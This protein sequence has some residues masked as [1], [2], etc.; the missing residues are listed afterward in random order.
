MIR[1]YVMSIFLSTHN[2]KIEVIDETFRE[3]IERS[4]VPVSID[5]KMP[6]LIKMVRAGVKKFFLGIGP[7]D[8]DMLRECIYNAR[9]RHYS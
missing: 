2:L 9:E 1:I 6:I 3:A 8:M 7:S 5:E 4:V